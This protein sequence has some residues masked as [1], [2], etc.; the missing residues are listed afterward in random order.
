MSPDWMIAD[1]NARWIGYRS[2]TDKTLEYII[3]TNSGLCKSAI[4]D[5]TENYYTSD[6]MCYNFTDKSI[7]QLNA[8]GQLERWNF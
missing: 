2:D 3:F 1:I 5:V 7:T 8:Q 4:V 6:Q